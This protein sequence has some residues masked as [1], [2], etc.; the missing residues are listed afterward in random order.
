MI[1][2]I[3]FI[4]TLKSETSGIKIKILVT[5]VSYNKGLV[6]SSLHCPRATL[7]FTSIQLVCYSVINI[8]YNNFLHISRPI[9][10]C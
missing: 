2:V 4:V 3:S 9:Q 5:I 7:G 6:L 1:C 10:S 8:I